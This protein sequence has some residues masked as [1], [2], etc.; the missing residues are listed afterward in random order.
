MMAG[1]ADVNPRELAVAYLSALGRADLD[2]LRALFTTGAVV[3]SPLYGPMPAE[4]FYAALLADTARSQLTLRGVMQG[5]A[6]DGTPLV[7]V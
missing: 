2:A 6:A 7:S 3:H 4:D 5:A 1:V